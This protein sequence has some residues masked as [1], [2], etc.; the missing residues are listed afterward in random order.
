M[1][2]V[3]IMHDRSKWL[4]GLRDFGACRFGDECNT[5]DT[6]RQRL[7]YLLCDCLGSNSGVETF[8]LDFFDFLVEFLDFVLDFL[9]EFLDVLDFLVEF[10]N[11]LVFFRIFWI[12]LWNVLIFLW[13][14]LVCLW[15]V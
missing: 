8:N 11:F 10:L 14:F 12:F 1:V 15:I 5:F 7:N 4:E 13:I 3:S 9:V 2:D 6:Q